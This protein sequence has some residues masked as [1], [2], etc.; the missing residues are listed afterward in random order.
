MIDDNSIEIRNIAGDIKVSF[1][2]ILH[3]IASH[4]GSFDVAKWTTIQVHPAMESKIL[5]VIDGVE[6]DQNSRR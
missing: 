5:V 2:M 4:G 1:L 6:F 3:I